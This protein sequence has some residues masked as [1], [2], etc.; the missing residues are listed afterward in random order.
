MGAMRH[1]ANLRLFPAVFPL[2]KDV[3]VG[4]DHAMH[5]V[6]TMEAAHQLLPSIES[7]VEGGLV[8]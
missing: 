6:K 1:L 3:S 4:D 8:R 2:P 7:K 5:C